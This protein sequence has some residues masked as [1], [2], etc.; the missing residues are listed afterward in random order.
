MTAITDKNP[1]TKGLILTEITVLN[2][3]TDKQIVYKKA[4]EFG[5]TFFYNEKI[6]GL[7]VINNIMS[8]GAKPEDAKTRGV[9]RLLDFSI[10]NLKFK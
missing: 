6:P 8:I 4:T 2:N 1:T 10:I 9:A 5:M 3:K 7:L